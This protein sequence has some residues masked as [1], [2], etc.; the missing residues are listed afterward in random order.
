MGFSNRQLFD[1][2]QAYGVAEGRNLS[3]L[4]ELNFYRSVNTDLASFNNEQ[5]FAHI[6]TYGAAEGRRFSPFVDLNFYRSANSDLSAMDDSQSVTAPSTL[7]IG[8]GTLLF[9]VFQPELLQS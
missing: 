5:A 2:L 1:H 8:W 6:Q 3:P 7:R 4:A 9:S